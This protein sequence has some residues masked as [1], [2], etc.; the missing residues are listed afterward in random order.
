MFYLILHESARNDNLTNRR[1][2]F[3]EGIQNLFFNLSVLWDYGFG[4]SANLLIRRQSAATPTN[5]TNQ[6]NSCY[7]DSVLRCLYIQR[8]FVVFIY[9]V[10]GFLTLRDKTNSLI[11]SLYN[12]FKIMDSKTDSTI[13]FDVVWNYFEN[14]KNPNTEFGRPQDIQDFLQFIIQRIEAEILQFF[15]DHDKHVLNKLNQF[16]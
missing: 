9:D 5:L 10:S 2:I 7:A 12:L 16:L 15:P 1:D 11:G 8:E 13:C 3:A 4:S 6:N 14:Q